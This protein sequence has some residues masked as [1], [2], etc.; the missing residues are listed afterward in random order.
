MPLSVRALN[1]PDW[2]SVQITQDQQMWRSSSL[3]SS[4][5]QN[6]ISNIS[7]WMQVLGGVQICLSSKKQPIFLV[8]WKIPVFVVLPF[9]FSL[10]LRK[11]LETFLTSPT[12][13]RNKCFPFWQQ[14]S[15][16]DKVGS[17]DHP[18]RSDGPS[19]KSKQEKFFWH[20]SLTLLYKAWTVCW[21]MF[22]QFRRCLMFIEFTQFSRWGFVQ[23]GDEMDLWSSSGISGDLHLES[24][25]SPPL[26]LNLYN[27]IWFNIL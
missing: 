26:S 13:C 2:L 9:C 6:K 14:A 15:L 23:K 8:F 16:L 11:E 17:I 27:I 10:N 3:Q 21:E 12:L 22:L 4:L 24:L 7:L 19:P 5:S 25:G 20:R 1:T 18:A